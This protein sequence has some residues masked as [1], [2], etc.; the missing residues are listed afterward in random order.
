MLL[1]DEQIESNK[2]TIITQLLAT[3][4]EG[5]G[6]LV[7]WL[8]TTDFFTAP[9]STKYHLSYKG[10][11]AEHSISVREAFRVL[12]HNFFEHKLT[13]ATTDITTLLHDVCKHDNYIPSTVARYCYNPSAEAGHGAK[14]V[15]LIKRFID[16]TEK[17]EAMIRWHMAHYVDTSEFKGVKNWLSEKHPEAHMLYFADHISTLFMEGEK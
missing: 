10:G 8:C 6:R 9:A 11:L 16:L 4:R 7:D 5:I 17:E 1:S 14:S 15:K 13:I 12:Q 3:N 2:I